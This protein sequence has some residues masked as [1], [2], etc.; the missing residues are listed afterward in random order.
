MQLPPLE[1]GAKEKEDLKKLE[2]AI[3]ANDDDKIVK[4]W[5]PALVAYPLSQQYKVRVEAAQ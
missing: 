3:R 2:E 1:G 4:C 5:T